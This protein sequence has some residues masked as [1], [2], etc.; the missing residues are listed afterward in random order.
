MLLSTKREARLLALKLR[1]AVYSD[2]S[3]VS[4]ALGMLS[5]ENCVPGHERVQKSHWFYAIDV[6][7]DQRLP[8]T[9]E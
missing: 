9:G 2:L 5:E 7:C 1:Q 3:K 4:A 6:V 8:M